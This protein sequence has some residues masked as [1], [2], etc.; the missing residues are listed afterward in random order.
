[1]TVLLFDRSDGVK[2]LFFLL[3]R[4]M[5]EIETEY[6]STRE[7]QLSIMARSDEA[8]PRVASCLVDLRQRW[9]ILGADATLFFVAP[10]AP[11]VAPSISPTEVEDSTIASSEEVGMPEYFCC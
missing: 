1:M 8:G 4:P 7:E 5:R 10:T 6:I 3:L 11:F 2:K 9:A